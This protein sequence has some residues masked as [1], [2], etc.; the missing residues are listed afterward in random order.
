MNISPSNIVETGYD[1]GFKFVDSKGDYY[2][3]F[4]HKDDKDRY[5]TGQTHT[6]TS[7]RIYD[8][9][10]PINT[11]PNS[12]VK[13]LGSNNAYNKHYNQNLATVL[14]KSDFI[15]PTDTDYSLGFFP[16]YIV[17]LKASTIPENN[18]YELNAINF[19]KYRNDVSFL[20]SYNAIV[21]GWKL[22][23]PL[24]DTYKDNIRI[25][26]GIIDT[27]KRSIQEAEKFITNLSLYFTDLIQFGKPS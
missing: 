13:T 27:N 15:Q 17:Q 1:Q 18:I 10:K 12:L 4:Y 22:T 11:D 6:I 26:S 8:T 16:R 23:G 5:W 3:G 21:V 7:I 9:R 24:H 25:A 19:N 14:L 20:N 2:K